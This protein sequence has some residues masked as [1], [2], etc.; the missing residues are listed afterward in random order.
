MSVYPRIWDH[1]RERKIVGETKVSWLVERSWAEPEKVSKKSPNK[2]GAHPQWFF[3]ENAQRLEFW[4]DS[5]FHAV[6]E[7]IGRYGR[8]IDAA[9]LHRVAELIGYM[10]TLNPSQPGTISET[11]ETK[12]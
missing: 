1:T 12:R 8:L 11:G 2:N 4:A 3:D 7:S 6:K 5:N 10:P 9:T